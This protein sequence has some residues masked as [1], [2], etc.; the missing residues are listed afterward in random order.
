MPTASGLPV[1]VSLA[2]ALAVPVFGLV[3]AAASLYI[4]WQQKRIA[5]IRLQHEL[6][7]RRFNVFVAAKTLLV[8]HLTNGK[9]TLEDYFAYRRG[10]ADAVFLLDAGVVEYLE[11]L[12]RQA[13]RLLHLSRQ[14]FEIRANISQETKYP[15]LVDESAKIETWLA[16]Q[17]DILIAKFKPAMRLD[18][19]S[20]A[21]R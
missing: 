20:G 14:Q 7:D 11:E 19:R 1:W 4:A 21:L 18:G 8:T 17:F 10:T 13:E 3:I 9:L 12:R 15:D 6:Y 16:Q 2:Q 5:D